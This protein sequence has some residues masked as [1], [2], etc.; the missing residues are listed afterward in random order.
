[1]I[2]KVNGATILSA[3]EIHSESWKESHR[4]FCSESFVAQHTVENQLLY[5]QEEM[6]GGKA[7]YLLIAQ[8]PAGIVS[9]KDNLIENLYV[10]PSEQ[11]KGYGT[12]LLR[13]AVAQCSGTPRLWIL[14]NNEKAYCLY[15]KYGFALT[16]NR[17]KLSD[18]ISELE[19][20]LERA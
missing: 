3:A 10:L 4:A 20:K 11:H 7:L 6:R 1:M 9:V 13:F 5:L 16:G 19:M 15:A 8:K 14:S 2:V 17:H 12:Q 18:A